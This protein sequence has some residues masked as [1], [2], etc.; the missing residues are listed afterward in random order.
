M[1]A[2]D[3]ILA[4]GHDDP[5]RENNDH[6]SR[7]LWQQGNLERLPGLERL[8]HDWPWWRQMIREYIGGA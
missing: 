1:R 6:L 2:M 3:V 4:I 5:N 8:G 7:L